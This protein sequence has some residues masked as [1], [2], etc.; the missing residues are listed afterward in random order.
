MIIFDLDGTIVNLKADWMLLRDILVDTYTERY[1]EPCNVERISTC[2][3]EVI[4]KKDETT[5]QEFFD[6]IR[7]FEFRYL[8]NTEFIEETIFFIKN[9][10][11][12]NVK[13]EA[14][15]AILSLNT[16]NTIVNALKLAKIYNKIDFIIGRE[17][18]R[19][20]KPAPDGLFRIQEQFNVNKNEMIFFGDL[21]NDILTGKNAG[22]DAYFIQDLIEL[23]KKKKET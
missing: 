2:L 21:E 18:V 19:K 12:F 17:D 9:K 6:I 16:R 8:K 14:K 11:L 13:E 22:I 10:E 5:L 7:Q 1:N 3:E 4:Q 23:V 20:W 15:N